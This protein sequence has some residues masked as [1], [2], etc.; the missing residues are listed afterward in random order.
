LATLGILIDLL[1][2]AG[3][4]GLEHLLVSLSANEANR[5][6]LGTESA[7]TPNA[8]QICV[9]GLWEGIDF[10]DALLGRRIGHIVVD[11]DVDALD[12]YATTEDIGADANAVLEVLEVGVAFDA[13]KGY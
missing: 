12:I 5:N 8:M 11:G 9:S 7:G 1:L 3:L 13:N 4:D 10:S 2:K 6:T